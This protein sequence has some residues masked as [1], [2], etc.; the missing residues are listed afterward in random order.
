MDGT[1]AII[2]L[3]V[4]LFAIVGGPLFGADSRQGWRNVDRKPRLRTV[5]SMHPD[6]WPPSEF[7]R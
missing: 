3:A 2:L 7:E 4:M 1:I 5:G 6:E